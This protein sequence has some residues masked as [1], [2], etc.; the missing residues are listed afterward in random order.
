M[1]VCVCTCACV[2]VRVC[3]EDVYTSQGD[4]PGT[5]ELQQ[6]VET[7]EQQ[8]SPVL[9]GV[10]YVKETSCI[11]YYHILLS[12]WETKIISLHESDA[13]GETVTVPSFSLFLSLILI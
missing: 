7:T 13:V 4:S 3:V 12:V 8:R 5:T 6:N 2:C 10:D 11:A 1:C 9:E